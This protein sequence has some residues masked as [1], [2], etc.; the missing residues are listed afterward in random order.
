MR[1]QAPSLPNVG[2][3]SFESVVA[4][5]VSAKAVAVREAE[6]EVAAGRAN[7][8]RRV[9]D[10]VEHVDVAYE[11]RHF[12]VAHLRNDREVDVRGHGPAG[13]RREFTRNPH[14]HGRLEDVHRIGR[15]AAVVV[16]VD[17]RVAKTNM[18]NNLER[19]IV[20]RQVAANADREDGRIER[21]ISGSTGDRALHVVVER[22]IAGVSREIEAVNSLPR[23]DRD[24]PEVGIVR[25]LADA[26]FGVSVARTN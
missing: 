23:I 14:A 25:I 19:L 2:R 9:V 15:N 10:V 16:D 18:R 24:A 4:S 3:T 17:L 7:G 5:V 20:D 1:L 13:G 8:E 6:R 26:L 11:R 21:F 22:E 12:L